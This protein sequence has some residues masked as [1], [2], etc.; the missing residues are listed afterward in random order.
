MTLVE[1][2]QHFPVQMLEISGATQAYRESGSGE[3]VLVLLHGISSGSGSW[4]QQLE[5]LG[6]HFRVIAWDAPGYGLSDPLN[7]A[8]PT[9]RVVISYAVFCVKKNMSYSL[10][11]TAV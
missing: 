3:Q 2:L 7:T 4:V 10:R 6:H 8:E 9:R 5:T 11:H 1:K